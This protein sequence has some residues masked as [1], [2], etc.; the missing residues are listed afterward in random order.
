ML[1]PCSLVTATFTGAA[2]GPV[3]HEREKLLAR[4][5]NVAY[6]SVHQITTGGAMHAVDPVQE[7]RLSH[8]KLPLERGPYP[9]AD[10]S[11]WPYAA[12]VAAQMTPWCGGDE[13]Q[14][15]WRGVAMAECGNGA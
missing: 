9:V 4:P 6:M 10:C 11:M 15:V 8:F 1:E 14:Q 5:E 3:L 7:L 2:P 12:S 13:L